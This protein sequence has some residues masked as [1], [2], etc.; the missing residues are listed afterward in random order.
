MVPNGSAFALAG[1]ALFFLGLSVHL[2]MLIRTT[3]DPF[4]NQSVPDTFQR[5]MMV[6]R[7]EQYPP[8]SIFHREAPLAWQIGHLLGTSVW[9]EGTSLAGSRV[10]GFLQQFTF[11]PRPGFL[12]SFVAIGLG[13]YGLVSQWRGDK[14][15]FAGF[16]TILL[17]NSVGL[18]LV[19]N[20]TATEVRDRDYFY[21]GAFQF[22]ALF[23][24]LGA[25]A[26]LR[27][28]WQ[29]T[30]QNALP[31][32]RAAAVGLLVVAL[33]PVLWPNHPKFYAHDRSEDVIARLSLIHI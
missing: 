27:T 18:L 9:K 17:I 11:L 25:G 28:I 33:L 4:I 30:R 32:A 15:L 14:R 31:L 12:D 5:L 6:I 8:R 21:F 7:R 16:L 10:I 29:A 1:I 26:L 2:F 24:A 3:Q 20:F 23:M 13:L 19:L 22:W